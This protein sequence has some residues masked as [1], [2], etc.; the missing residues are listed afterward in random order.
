MLRATP[1]AALGNIAVGLQLLDGASANTIGGT[2]AAAGNLIS[3][4]GLGLAIVGAASRGNAVLGNFIG[5]D[6]AA[7]PGTGQP[8]RPASS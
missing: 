3:G 5:T 4:N 8:R 6:A 1:T 2:A 7:S